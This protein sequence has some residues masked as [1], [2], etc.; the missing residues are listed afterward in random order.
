M[1]G[2]KKDILCVFDNASV[3]ADAIDAVMEDYKED[4]VE[5]TYLQVDVNTDV[6]TSEGNLRDMK[7]EMFDMLRSDMSPHARNRHHGGEQEKYE[8]PE[9]TLHILDLKVKAK[10][11]DNIDGLLWSAGGF[12]SRRSKGWFKSRAK[13]NIAFVWSMEQFFKTLMKIA[14]DRKQ[15]SKTDF[16]N[17]YK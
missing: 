3:M 14:T 11:F 4:I 6:K 15:K 16:D 8:K 17:Q 13:K 9:Q 2:K 12:Q 10:C 5:F 7:R 1:R